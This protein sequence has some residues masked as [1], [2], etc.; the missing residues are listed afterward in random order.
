MTQ[1]EMSKEEFGRI[2]DELYKT[3]I[4]PLVETEDNIGKLILI[5]VNTGDYDIYE[6]AD[7]INRTDQMLIKHPDAQLL[8]LRIGYDAVQAFGGYRPM[9][10]KR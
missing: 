7:A 9:P 2:A 3:C 8:E 5:N 10:S 4:R 6:R 1:Q